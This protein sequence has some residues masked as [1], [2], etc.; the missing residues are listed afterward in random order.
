L[1]ARIP[2][3]AVA[4]CAGV[5]DDGAISA[6]TPSRIDR[7][8]AA[9]VDA[10]VNLHE[11]TRAMPLRAFV[12]F[13]SVAG[14]AGT[15]GQAN[16]AAANS[17]LDAL[18]TARSRAGLAGQSLAWGLWEPSSDGMSAGL[19]A[20][21]LARLRR[22]GIAPLSSE[23]GLALFAEA[24]ARPEPLLVPVQ[25]DLSAIADEPQPLLRNLMK[26]RLPAAARSTVADAGDVKRRLS[27]LAPDE[28]RLALLELVRAEVSSVFRM[29]GQIVPDDE[30]LKSLGLD[31]LMA[32]ELRDR[33]A[34]RL[35]VPLSSTLAFD[36]PT[37]G[38]IA[39]FTAGLLGEQATPLPLAPAG[40]IDELS[41][42]ELISLM[43]SL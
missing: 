4:H 35:G 12:L 14:I 36:H 15:A 24:L 33:V 22:Q 43:R 21:D 40:P 20:A 41:N 39:L 6:M 1:L 19:S 25:L 17:F 29:P 27:R 34:A 30:P 8:F 18:A 2:I 10:A 11:L 32:L 31:S 5:V 37:V 23:R 26:V 13:S 3:D 38:Q 7:V 28:R 9:K 42:E 16:Y